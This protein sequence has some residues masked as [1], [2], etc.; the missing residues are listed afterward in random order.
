V[1]SRGAQHAIHL[2]AYTICTPLTLLTRDLFC[3]VSD[4]EPCLAVVRKWLGCCLQRRRRE[5]L[6]AMSY[7]YLFKYIIIGDTGRVCG[8]FSGGFSGVGLWFVLLRVGV[9]VVGR[10]VIVG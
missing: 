2:L 4:L 6:G 1:Q 10:I 3:R 8:D 7:A 9:R 5:H